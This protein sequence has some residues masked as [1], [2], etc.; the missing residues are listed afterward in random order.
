MKYDIS[1]LNKRT[2]AA[3]EA[4]DINNDKTTERSDCFFTKQIGST[5]YKV[6]VCFKEDSAETMEDKILRMIDR[7][8]STN[9]LN[10]DIMNSPQMS[11]PV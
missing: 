11:R 1:V 7:E 3:A 9:G 2:Q 8:F 10:G 5:L 4:L 6:K